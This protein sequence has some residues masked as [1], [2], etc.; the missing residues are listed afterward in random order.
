RDRGDWIVFPNVDRL[1]KPRP[2]CGSGCASGQVCV[3]EGGDQ[4]RCA[5]PAPSTTPCAPACTGKQSCVLGADGTTPVCRGSL[6]ALALTDLPMGI[7]LTP[8]LAFLDDRAV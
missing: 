5:R 8:S 6:S 1:D 7:G 2:P 3:D 4:S